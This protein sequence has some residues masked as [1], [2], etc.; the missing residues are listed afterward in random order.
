MGGRTI[1]EQR[2]ALG[3]KPDGHL[4]SLIHT[5]L[6]VTPSHARYAEQCTFPTRHLYSTD[7]LYIAQHV[8]NL[9]VVANTW[10]RAPGESI[11]TFAVESALDELA[12]ELRM[13]PIALRRSIEPKLDPTTGNEFSSRNLVEA[14]QR[15]ADKFGW[16]SRNPQPRS[17]RDGGWLVGQGV[18]TAYYPAVRIPGEARVRVNS[19]GTATI[20][21]AANEMGM[22]VATSQLQ[23]AA[24]RLG[25][26]LHCVEFNYGDSQ[27]PSSPMAGGPVKL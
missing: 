19:D 22:G 6:T 11:G 8:V 1:A 15:G 5:G 13:D 3:A 17:Q 23:H 12:I 20:H 26:P 24:D 10:M 16:A 4:T 14:Y 7:S 21:A 18:A 27:M 2:V 9:D 25:M